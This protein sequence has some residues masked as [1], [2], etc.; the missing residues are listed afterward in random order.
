[1]RLFYV[2]N[3]R[4]PT[5]KAHG[6]QVM[7]MCEA[8]ADFG[9]EVELII[10]RRKNPIKKDAFDFY[11]IKRNFKIKKVFALDPPYV[12]GLGLVT[13]YLQ[14][15]SLGLSM[16]L[17]VLFNPRKYS[18][19]SIFYFRDRFSPWLLAL[20]NRKVFI[21]FHAFRSHF[22][23]FK[24][25]FP[26]L[27][28]MILLTK[29]AKED[30]I[31][32]G[33]GEEKILIAPD[34]VDLDIFNLNISKEEARNKLRLP[35]SKKIIIYT[36]R[37]KTMGMDKGLGDILRAIKLSDNTH[38]L[39]IAVGGSE[40]EIKFYKRVVDDLSVS[41]QVN[42]IGLVPQNELAVYQKAADALLMPFPLNEHYAYYM[43]PLKMFEYMASKRPIIASDLPSI[44]EVLSENSS[45]IIEPCNPA[46]LAEGI[47]KCLSDN[48]LANKI[49]EQAFDD[50]HNYTWNKRVKNIM[51]F[52]KSR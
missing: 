48:E 41:A 18:T 50:I 6:L 16:F 8:F 22:G 5:E 32:L 15:I 38:I 30:F 1:M 20:I 25:L 31:N 9:L 19:D 36:G 47:K 43:S 45:I 7:K 10:P 51:D 23:Q 42:F 17:R 49:A 40:E 46:S 28:G 39:F 33:V 2:A 35:L 13:L 4:I 52:I 44:R 29:K 11:G 21:E 12:K 24:F 37:F 26:R 34:S 14:N 3:A 27:G